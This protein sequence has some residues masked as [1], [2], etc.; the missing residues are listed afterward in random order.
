MTAATG[1]PSPAL[2][3]WCKTPSGAL[4]EVLA[5]AGVDYL[6]ADQ[7]HGLIDDAALL[8]LAQAA[9]A[10]G[11]RLLTRVAA[12]DPAAIQ[13]VIDIG[14]NGVLV[15]GVNDADTARRTA[16]FFDYPPDGH[17]S[18]GSTRA[19]LAKDGAAPM[20]STRPLF[21]PMVETSAAVENIDSVLATP[22]V[23]GI[24]IGP[25]DLSMSLGLGAGRHT[26]DPRVTAAMAAVTAAC[27]REV[28]LLATGVADPAAIVPT[29]DSGFDFVTV[30]SD[31]AILQ[32]ALRS[33]VDAARG[34]LRSR[35][36]DG[37]RGSP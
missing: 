8:S 37:G 3:V 28:K 34:A 1:F 23:D 30:G 17:R 15:P 14:V 33:R 20:A 9:G 25:V 7:Q 13:R 35:P 31:W 6:C 11:C 2:G 5:S 4:A 16:G 19:L 21:F 26:D 32:S 24:Y 29:I 18:F 12:N 27:K 36:D 22:G 10:W